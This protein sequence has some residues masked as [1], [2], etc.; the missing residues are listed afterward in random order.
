MSTKECLQYFGE[1][2]PKN[3]EWIDDSS[4]NVVFRDDTSA[5]RAIFGMGKPIPTGSAPEQQGPL[6]LFGICISVVLSCTLKQQS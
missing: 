6:G 1:Y 3:V 2:G 5:K 4:C